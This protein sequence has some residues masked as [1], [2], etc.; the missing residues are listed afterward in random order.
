MLW[1]LLQGEKHSRPP[2]LAP[3]PGPVWLAGRCLRCCTAC[4]MEQ[5]ECV[6]PPAV[7]LKGK[8]TELLRSA[9]LKLEGHGGELGE[10]GARTSSITG[11]GCVIG[12]AESEGKEIGVWR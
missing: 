6:I 10:D 3:V 9:L 5:F 12:R 11:H 8:L 2:L 7:E 4:R 1:Y